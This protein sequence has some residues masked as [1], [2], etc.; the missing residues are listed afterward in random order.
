MAPKIVLLPGDGIGPEVTAAAVE[1]L[2]RLADFEFAEF[3]FGATAIKYC[4]TPLMA[5]ALAECRS[6]DAVLV[7]AVGTATHETAPDVPKAGAGLLRLRSELQLYA[8]IRPVRAWSALSGLGPLRADLVTGADL[9]I[10]RELTGGLYAGVAQRSADH[11]YDTCTYT[12]A[13]IERIAHVAFRLASRPGRRG[14]V[15]SVDKA[16]VLETS[17]L[18]RETL[19][20]VGQ[21]KFPDLELRHLLVDAA[22]LALISDPRQFD[23]LVTEN[24]FG[25]ILSDEAAAITGSLGMLPSASLGDEAVAL[26]EP[27]HGSAPDIAGAGIANPCGA[28]LS[29]ALLLRHLPGREREAESIE[30]AVAGA[31]AQGILTPDIGGTA[32]TADVTRAVL[33]RLG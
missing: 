11:A 13:E 12:V 1:V 23:V 5:E 33:D 25:D 26:F 27:V 6:A 15:T 18:W 31:L 17:R 20:A 24:M 9:I 28:I 19:T 10:V 14:R 22:A 30:I 16:N 7:G 21:Q 3:P 2:S 4:G 8:N 29:A 32:T